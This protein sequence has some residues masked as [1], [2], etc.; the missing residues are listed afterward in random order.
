[1]TPKERKAEIEKVRKSIRDLFKEKR[2]IGGKIAEQSAY[3]ERLRLD[4]LQNES[5]PEETP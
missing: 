4:Q 5:L 3:L 2:A 1:M